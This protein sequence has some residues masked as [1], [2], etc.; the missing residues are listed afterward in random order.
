M[1]IGGRCRVAASKT[2]GGSMDGSWNRA[3]RGPQVLPLINE[4]AATI[5]VEAGPG[6]GKTFGLVRRVERIL[7]P[8]GIGAEGSEVLVVAFNRVIAK[9]LSLEIGTRLKTFAHNGDPAIRTI[10]SL[11]LQV[12]GEDLRLLLPHE[13]EAMV[14]DVLCEFPRLRKHYKRAK[15]A[16]QAL[17][18]H[19][20]RHAEHLELWKAARRWLDRHKAFLVGDLPG[21]F[22]DRLQGGDFP[23][24][25]YQFVIVDEFQDLTAGEQQLMFRLRAEGGQLVALGDPRQ[26]IYTFRG[27]DREGLAKLEELDFAAGGDGTVLDVPMTEC[28][29]CPSDVVKAANRLMALSDAAAMV[30][31]SK[32]VAN[33]HVVTWP[34]PHVEAEGMAR[35]ILANL[36]ANPDDRHLVMVTRRK[37]GY[38]LRDRIANA[39]PAVRVDLSFSESLLETWAVREAFIFFCLIVDPDAPTWRA[40]F[41]YKNSGTGDKFLAPRRNAD[42]YLKFLASQKD[43][44]SD[45]AVKALASEGR[46]KTRGEGG[47]ALWDRASRFEALLA[48]AEDYDIDNPAAFLAALFDDTDWVTDE[49]HDAETARLDLQLLLAKASALLTDAEGTKK[50]KGAAGIDRL[51]AVA[52]RLRYQIA[53]REPFEAGEA[54]QI[55]VATLWGAK[56]VTAEHV[57]LIGACDEAIPGEMKD[58]YPGTEVDFLDEQRRLFYVSITRS[59]K[60]LVISRATGALTA[61]A[62]KM[63]L[64]I[65]PGFARVNLQMSRFLREILTQLPNA[66][67]GGKW[68]GCC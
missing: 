64:A 29:R 17:R 32:T 8:D 24:Q 10:H 66:V 21:L 14:Y 46:T 16:E 35:A 62:M 22:L 1:M 15:K 27:N 33:L 31:V 39:D 2:M 56:G 13:R 48:N 49:Y 60:T 19:E 26:S 40:W 42:A 51:R 52:N 23:D 3:V 58:E 34:D 61:E 43:V 55:Q 18:D 28:Q 36:Q 67:A 50:L 41:A 12:I 9:Q 57:Y 45:A 53:T 54:A 7:H 38:W 20:A 47:G 59:K 68:S 11:C 37:F 65:M 30:P 6:T 4:D 25:A 44:I 63:G 5:R